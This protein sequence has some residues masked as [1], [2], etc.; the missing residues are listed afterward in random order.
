MG[1]LE[2]FS[3]VFVF[4]NR[5]TLHPTWSHE[6]SHVRLTRSLIVLNF[7]YTYSCVNGLCFGYFQTNRSIQNYLCVLTFCPYTVSCIKSL[8]PML[9]ILYKL[10]SDSYILRFL[11]V[12]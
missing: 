8:I 3:R 2:S 11:K 1:S 12:G 5:L 7:F 6:N 4:F 10:L 9:V